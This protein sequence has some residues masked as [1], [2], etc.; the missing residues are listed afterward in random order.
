MLNINKVKILGDFKSVSTL[1]NS[2]LYTK[3][4]GQFLFNNN[5]VSKWETMFLL[6]FS[7]LSQEDT[8]RSHSLSCS[9]QYVGDYFCYLWMKYT[10]IWATDLPLSCIPY[11][12]C[13]LLNKTVCQG[14]VNTA[15]YPVKCLSWCVRYINLVKI[16][17]P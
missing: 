10:E 8:C 15:I 11:I 14:I 12:K 16:G 1:N 9:G 7:V 13:S 3:K 17:V 2:K 6:K 5:A 4:L